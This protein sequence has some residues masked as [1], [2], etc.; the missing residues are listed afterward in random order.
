[1]GEIKDYFKRL[2]KGEISLFVSFWFWFIGLSFFVELFFQIKFDQNLFINNNYSE[3]LLFSS[4]FIYSI[5]IFIIIFT[6]ANKD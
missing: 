5:L 4:T 3:L 1:M 2:F 6:S